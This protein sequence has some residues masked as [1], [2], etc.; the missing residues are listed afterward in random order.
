MADPVLIPA[1]RRRAQN[2]ASQRA[3]RER[4]ERHV[5]NLEQQL[6][7]LHQRYQDLLRCYDEQKEEI[8]NLKEQ[9]H[10]VSSDSVPLRA[11]QNN[12]LEFA[13]AIPSQSFQGDIDLSRNPQ[14]APL[15]PHSQSV[16]PA[17]NFEKQIP[18]S[19]T[20][21]SEEHT[22]FGP[23]LPLTPAEQSGNVAMFRLLDPFFASGEDSKCYDIGGFPEVQQQQ[24]QQDDFGSPDFGKK[25]AKVLQAT[26][27]M[28]GNEQ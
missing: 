15:I 1:Q 8:Y 6:E 27:L 17:S 16:T 28:D 13:S 3:F 22:P 4:K 12:A 24:E 21:F 19:R 20:P 10:E 18:A 5:K 11:S 23:L 25:F 9:L 14:N 2:R 7:D 26:H